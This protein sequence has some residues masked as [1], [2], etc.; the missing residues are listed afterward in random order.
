MI[1]QVDRHDGIIHSIQPRLIPHHA[2]RDRPS[3]AH[4]H[5][6]GAAH[7]GFRADGRR[8]GPEEQLVLARGAASALGRRQALESGRDGGAQLRLAIGRDAPWVGRYT[9]MRAAIIILPLPALTGLQ[10]IFALDQHE[11]AAVDEALQ[12][13]GDA[14]AQRGAPGRQILDQQVGQDIGGGVNPY[15]GGAAR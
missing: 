10:A 9:R 6:D 3:V 14:L 1:R 8:L 12:Q 5:G 4:P 15:I 7:A 2:L 11:H 13:R